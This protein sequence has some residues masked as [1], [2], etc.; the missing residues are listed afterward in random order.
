MSKQG[1]LESDG[2]PNQVTIIRK[3]QAPIKTLRSSAV[4]NL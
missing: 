1:R 4:S 2:D 3:K